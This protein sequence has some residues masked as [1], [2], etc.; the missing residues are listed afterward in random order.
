M[1]EAR[2]IASA[3]ECVRGRAPLGDLLVQEEDVSAGF[4]CKVER[5]FAPRKRHVT[6]AA[7]TTWVCVES[8][9]RFKGR[10]NRYR[11][12]RP[13]HGKGN[14]VACAWPG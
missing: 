7:V 3:L 4:L 10:R 8:D 2:T 5:M 13:N 9:M 12:H 6:T 14:T 1:E 11:Y